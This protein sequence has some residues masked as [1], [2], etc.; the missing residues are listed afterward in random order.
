MWLEGRVVSPNLSLYTVLLLL[1]DF[2]TEVSATQRYL[3][4]ENPKWKIMEAAGG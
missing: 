2:T 3:G 4:A 1:H